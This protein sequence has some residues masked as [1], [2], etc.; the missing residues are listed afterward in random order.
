MIRFGL[1]LLALLALPATVQGENNYN[2][3]FIAVD[4]LRPE[5]G[6][7]GRSPTVSPNLDQLAQHSCVFRQHFVQVPTCGASRFAML[8]GRSPKQT[9][10]LGNEALYNGKTALSQQQLPAAQSMP[11][12]FRRSGYHTTLIGKISHTADGKVYAYN[13]Q[14][15]GRD[16]VPH[17][18]D[19][20]A[21]PYGP[22]KRGWGIF[23]AYADG[24]HREDGQGNSDLMQFTAEEDTDLPDGL[25]AQTAVE[26][27][28]RYQQTGE[29]FFLGLGFFKPHLPFVATKQDWE[30]VDAMDIEPAPHG[31]KPE[32]TYWHKSGE[33]YKYRMDFPK[34]NPLAE[35][36]QIKARKAYLA[37]VRYTDRQIGK[38]LAALQETGLDQSTIVVVWGDHGWHLGE[39]AIWGK[40]SSLERALKSPLF[41]KL[42]G[43][44]DQGQATN[45][46]AETL[47][48]YPTLIDLCQPKFQ[49]TTFP[50]DGISQ[51]AVVRGEKEKVRDTAISYW[52]GGQVSIRSN[53][54]RL[55]AR[56]RG[57]KMENIELY[58]IHKSPD[59]TDNLATDKPEV[60]AKLLEAAQEAN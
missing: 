59:P 24:K 37:C 13:G 51:A 39:S 33:F 47:D 4:D 43:V 48:I 11:E 34:T 2:V 46:L 32:T 31:T 16:E 53:D 26:K 19:E 8:T 49:E 5:L 12:L 18:W 44:T 58:D 9:K 10:A 27:L 3:L 6:S 56:K 29:R 40:H 42:P 52:Q 50:L 41:I 30:A 55:I 7:F 17:A 57:G 60:V 25:M 28:K 21:T 36:D 15:D 38:V 45:A 14:G 35:A 23:F 54:Y 22:W 1:F 20:L